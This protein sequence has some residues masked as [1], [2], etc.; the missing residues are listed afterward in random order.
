MMTV[1]AFVDRDDEVHCHR[2]D[3][4]DE[5]QPADRRTS[6]VN[7]P[8]PRRTSDL[9]HDDE[10]KSGDRGRRHR[11]EFPVAVRMVHVGRLARDPDA[12]EGGDVRE[13]IGQRVQAVRDDADRT[14]DVT[15]HELGAGDGKV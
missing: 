12:E 4:D 6:A 7:E 3:H 13:R 15:E 10:Q 2:P 14:G 9:D 1:V 8:L 11:F 5:R